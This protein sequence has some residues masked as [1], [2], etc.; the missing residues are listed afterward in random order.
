MNSV[1]TGQRKQAGPAGKDK[2]G[3][4]KNNVE[5]VEK[6]VSYLPPHPVKVQH[7]VFTNNNFKISCN[8]SCDCFCQLLP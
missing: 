7:Q 1:Q 5:T 2:E 3:G 6:Q 8:G 4:N